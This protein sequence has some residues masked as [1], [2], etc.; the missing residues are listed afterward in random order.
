MARNEEKAQMMMN[1]WTTMKEQ[2][3]KPERGRRPFLSSECDNLQDAELWRR[4]IIRETTKSVH[5]IQNA[6]A[7]EH[8]IRDLNDQINKL[9]RERTHWDKR[10]VELG[11]PDY[12]ANAPK[13]YDADGRELPGGGG[14]MYFGAA[15]DLP[16]VRELFH[17]SDVENP[18]RT[19]KDMYQF[20]TPDYYGYRD[21]EDGVLVAKEAVTEKR[22]VQEAVL[23]WQAEK[24][25]RVEDGEEEEGGADDEDVQDVQGQAAAAASAATSAQ[26]RAHV[27]VP[28]Q[29]AIKEAILKRK[30][31]ALLKRL[32]GGE[33]TPEDDIE[34]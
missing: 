21:E 22:K 17:K 3:A 19:R 13:S 24:R 15:K 34:D 31:L 30:K 12:A 32:D 26:V 1:K 29:D 6:G 33:A 18:R 5:L 28:S 14:Y 9:L 25:R 10:I 8:K 11:G 2:M 20:I 16:G 7:G 27:P 23:E 4:D